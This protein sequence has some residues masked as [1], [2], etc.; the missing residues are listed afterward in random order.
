[1]LLLSENVFALRNIGRNIHHVCENNGSQFLSGLRNYWSQFLLGLRNYGSQF[2][3]GL[4][5]YGSQFFRRGRNHGSKVWIEMARPRP[6]LGLDTPR[7][8]TLGYHGTNRLWAKDTEMKVRCWNDPWVS[9]KLWLNLDMLG[10]TLY[11]AYLWGW[12]NMRKTSE[13]HVPRVAET[14]NVSVVSQKHLRVPPYKF[15]SLLHGFQGG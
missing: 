2:L 4:R 8:F 3:L 1:M 13:Q 14:R 9:V 11:S 7:G 10:A 6:K 5:N 15:R 12:L